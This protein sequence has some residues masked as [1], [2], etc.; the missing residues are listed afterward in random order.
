MNPVPRQLEALGWNRRA[1]TEDDFERCCEQEGIEVI[2]AETLPYPAVSGLYTELRGVPVIAISPRSKGLRRTLTLFHEL[3]HHFMHSPDSGLF[4]KASYRKFD[5]QARAVA[6]CAL[7]PEPLL[8]RFIK[9][10][11]Y[12]DDTL[13]H[14][15]LN[16]RLKV[17]EQ[18]GF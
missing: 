13:P 6:L 10:E 16:A 11:V 14:E 2:E 4:P 7:V 18:F 15:L 17:L 8:R 12:E 1:L 9:G 5:N 3:A